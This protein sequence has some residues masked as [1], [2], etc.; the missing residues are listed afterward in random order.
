MVLF[1][2]PTTVA[3]LQCTGIVGWGWLRSSRVSQKIIP[4]WQIR[5]R[6]LSLASAADAAT[7]CSIEHSMWNA[8]FN[9][10]GLLSLGIHPIKNAHMLCYVP[11]AL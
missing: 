10:M 3:L 7:N 8:P 2:I 5:K 1:A 4:S 6:A 9:F 11:L